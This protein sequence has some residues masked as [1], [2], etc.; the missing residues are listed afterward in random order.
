MLI[1]DLPYFLQEEVK[2]ENDIQS[3]LDLNNI[4]ILAG[5]FNWARSKKG[6][7]YWALVDMGIFP[8]DNRVK[9]TLKVSFKFKTNS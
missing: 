4:L 3:K 5:A 6:Y 7:K 8:E 1:R 2:M 9:K